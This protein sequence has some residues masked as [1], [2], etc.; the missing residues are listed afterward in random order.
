MKPKS[1]PKKTSDRNFAT[2]CVPKSSEPSAPG[3]YLLAL[4][5][6]KPT[7]ATG[8][9]KRRVKG[10]KEPKPVQFEGRGR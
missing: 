7:K 2:R 3:P 8:K 6:G 4:A 5:C 10:P 9:I 1:T